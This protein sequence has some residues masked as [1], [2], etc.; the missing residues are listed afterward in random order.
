MKSKPSLIR[1][2]CEQIAELNQQTFITGWRIVAQNDLPSVFPEDLKQK[3]GSA[4]VITAPTSTGGTYLAFS[5]NRIDTK[6]KAIDI[7]PFGLI[8]SS[9]GVGSWG[10]FLHHGDWDSRT[11]IPP[12]TFW[13][14]VPQSGIGNY[15]LSNPPTGR[16]K[17][18]LGELPVGHRNAF[19]AIVLELRHRIDG[20]GRN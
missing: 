5:A 12:A 19:D 11:E 1:L 3:I 2:S 10:V 20:S 15:F 9:T 17:G 7:E 16:Q 4:V 14:A 13:D 18:S 6:A 8:V